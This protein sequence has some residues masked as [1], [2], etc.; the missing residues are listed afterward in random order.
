MCAGKGSSVQQMPFVRQVCVQSFVPEGLPGAEAE[1]LPFMVL[2]LSDGT[3]AVYKA[4]RCAHDLCRLV[5]TR[6]VC[7]GGNVLCC[8]CLTAAAVLRPFAD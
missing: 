2:L 1:S 3:L 5:C 7:S 4:F 6:L 8:V